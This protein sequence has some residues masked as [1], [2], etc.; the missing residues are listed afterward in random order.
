MKKAIVSQSPGN[1]RPKL[2]KLL[3]IMKFT[4]IL[5]LVVCLHAF[6]NGYSQKISLSVKNMELKKLFTLIQRQ[7]NYRFLYEDQQLPRNRKVDLAV[8]NA[9]INA[10]LDDVLQN[11]TL[12][13]RVLNDNLVV[14]TAG[15]TKTVTQTIR[16]KITDEKGE[17]L[18]GVNI[19]VK[20]SSGGVT[21]N[22]N[23]EFSI[24]VPDNA[25]LEVSYI[26]YLTQD[27][28]IK[29]DAPIA[30]SLIPGDKNLQEVVVVGYGTQKKVNL[31]GAVDAVT[32]KQLENRP[33]MN[34]G[35]GLQGLIPNLN[36]TV[37]NGRATT[38]PAFNIRGVTSLNGGE[39]LILVDNIPFTVAEV[40]RLNPNDI[41][42]VTALKDA[43]SAAI[44]GAR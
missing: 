7:T 16:G 43:A 40:A 18:V 36:I 14:L 33:L 30:I 35:T 11:T 22:I 5:L 34:L 23:G 41:E 37:P 13:Y 27:V 1:T 42:S 26:G 25:V 6:G 38:A 19:K 10:V 39:P 28:Q 8:Q 31:T 24:E 17:P 21:T 9:S 2:F 32:S 4:A 20:G 29:S 15:D 44:Y 3:L 12:H